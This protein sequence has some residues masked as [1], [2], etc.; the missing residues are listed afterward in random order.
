MSRI[1]PRYRR[2]PAA[3]L[4]ALALT[5]CATEPDGPD[6]PSD[7]A[8][9]ENGAAA[10]T[11]AP[12]LTEEPPP[13][14]A[15]GTDYQNCTSR[16][17]VEVTDGTVFEYDDFTLTITDVTEDG[18]EVSRE[19]DSGGT[20]TTSISGGYCVSYMSANSSSSS[21]YGGFDGEPPG[22]EPAD[23]ELALELLYVADGTA[24]IRLTMG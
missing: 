8:S 1:D 17:E 7:P 21:C 11:A 24:I 3:L 20:G 22:P 12:S 19:D 15:D 23:G 5:G 18:I 6:S 10:S 14:A 13:V 9:S 4:T 16:C 2:F